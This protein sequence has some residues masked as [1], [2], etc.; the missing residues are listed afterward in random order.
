[1]PILLR[2]AAGSRRRQ[3]PEVAPGRKTAAAPRRGGAAAMNFWLTAPCRVDRLPPRRQ[4][5]PSPGRTRTSDQAVNSR[6][7]YQLSYRGSE[8]PISPRAATLLEAGSGIEP[9]Y[10]D[11]QSSA[12][13]L[14]HPAD[15]LGPRAGRSRGVSPIRQGPDIGAGGGAGQARGAARAGGDCCRSA[16]QPIYFAASRSAKSDKAMARVT[17]EDCVVRVPN[18]FEL[19]LLA[20]QRAR[21][22]SSGAPLTVDRD[23]DKNPV[24][25]LRE[26]A[27]ETISLEQL[28]NALVRGLQK[29]VEL[30]P[31][32]FGVSPPHGTGAGEAAEEG[33]EEEELA[34]GSLEEEIEEDMLSV[35]GETDFGEEPDEE[36]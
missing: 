22:L 6:S 5:A 29:H 32:L 19:V 33:R 1:M 23:D 31:S 28:R 13:P 12:S 10:E 11:L 34:E 8:R 24:V 2:P 21:D 14:C 25:A 26:I 30:D 20:A 16:P 15:R 4:A 7:L 18:R 17:V 9:L 3:P 35:E 27:D 36:P